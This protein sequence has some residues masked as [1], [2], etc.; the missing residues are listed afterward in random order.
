MALQAKCA[1][2]HYAGRGRGI[3]DAFDARGLSKGLAGQSAGI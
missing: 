2:W 1:M 3:H